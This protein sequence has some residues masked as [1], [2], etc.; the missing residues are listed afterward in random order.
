M[1][2]AE[3]GSPDPV[4]QQLWDALNQARLQRAA[5]ATLAHLEDQV[6]WFYLPLARSVTAVHPVLTENAAGAQ[7]AAEIGLAEAVLE[8]RRSDGT[9][10]PRFARDRIN[11]QLGEVQA[12]QLQARQRRDRAGRHRDNP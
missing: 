4:A 1:T 12:R 9:G 8:W 5:P 2:P 7:Q 11:A 10:F 3:A 6:F